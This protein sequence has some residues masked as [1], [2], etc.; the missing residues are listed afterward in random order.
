MLFFHLVHRQERQKRVRLRARARSRSR[1]RT[2]TAA[3]A[4][5]AHRHG[6]QLVQRVLG[7]VRVLRVLLLVVVLVHEHVRVELGER[8][9][10][11]GEAGDGVAREEPGAVG[12]ELAELL[13][14]VLA[15]MIWF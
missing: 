6:G 12:P 2:R 13:G 3:T 5:A 4:A 8:G 10:E 14:A 15:Q 1:A 7:R 9:E 11:G